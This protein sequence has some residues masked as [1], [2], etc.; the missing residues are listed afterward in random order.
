MDVQTWLDSLATPGRPD[1]F[2]MKQL[3]HTAG[4]TVPKSVR[5]GPEEDVA[6]IG[7]PGPYAAKVCTP[8]I[9]HKTDCNGVHLDLG[10]AHVQA[11]V[12]DLRLRFPGTPVLV[13]EQVRWQGM[14]FILGALVDPVFGPAVMVGT[15]GILTELTQDVAFRLAPCPVAEARRMLAGL[16]AAP[17][18]R[19]YRGI[20]LDADGLARAVSTVADLILPLSDRFHQLDLNPIVS[21]NGQ[22]T[23]L[24][25][26]VTPEN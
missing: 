5:L 15:G 1:E 17:L 20:H 16:D 8:D 2:E 24:D 18:F 6:G 7:F 12:E 3:L 10:I 23:V 11:A 13:E 14:E 4:I 9:P 25:A 21:V 19:G 22:W 26:Q